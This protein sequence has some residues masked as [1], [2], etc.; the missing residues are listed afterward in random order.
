MSC[1]CGGRSG[2]GGW[3]VP[4]KLCHCRFEQE[5]PCRRH[6]LRVQGMPGA[7][8]REDLGFEFLIAKLPGPAFMHLLQ[9]NT[10]SI[11]GGIL[12]RLKQDCTRELL[13]CN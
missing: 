1:C 11:V 8:E 6:E 3:N 7:D 12:D 5:Q 13:L 4:R 10:L 2:C 9:L